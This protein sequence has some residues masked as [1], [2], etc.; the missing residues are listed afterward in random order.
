MSR[1]KIKKI[2]FTKKSCGVSINFASLLKKFK[3]S[4]FFLFFLIFLTSYLS[5]LIS[6]NL[7]INLYKWEYRGNFYYLF[8][9]FSVT[10]QIVNGSIHVDWTKLLLILFILYF[11]L[12]ITL[13]FASNY[14]Q[15]YY[16]REMQVYITKKLLNFAAKNKDLI[17]QKTSEKVYTLNQTVPEFSRQIFIIPLKLL[18]ILVDLGL[19]IFSLV[20]LIKSR[21]LAEI[22]PL[23][24]AF[25]LTNLIWL[26]SFYFFTY[27]LRKLNKRKR[28]NYK[29][30]EKIQIRIFC[31]NL[32][33]GLN[34][35][36]LPNQLP[37]L[38][39]IYSLLDKNSSKTSSSFFLS[40]LAELPDLVVPGITILFLFFYY[41][42]WSGGS[43]NLDWGAYFLAYNLQ[44]ILSRGKN[45]FHWLAQTAK[46]R[47]N[48]DRIEEFFG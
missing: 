35:S 24:I 12:K 36:L 31:E 37:N 33:G 48:R 23:T 2:T 25:L 44:R 20:F 41:Q 21:N 9:K 29:E 15:K 16:Q 40:E 43:G 1:G 42:I 32:N 17:A 28:W 46:F 39:K 19:E 4:F 10:K 34:K 47:E 5:F 38:G 22:V 7:R 14:F 18:E 8:D 3:G 13:H 26:T 27:K 30:E 6:F 45:F 11:P